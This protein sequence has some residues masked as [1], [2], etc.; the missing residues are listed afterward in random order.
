MTW[1]GAPWLYGALDRALEGAA[2]EMNGLRAAGGAEELQAG[3]AILDI[4]LESEWDKAAEK[5]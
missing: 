1:G 2:W 4:Q 5:Y 3:A